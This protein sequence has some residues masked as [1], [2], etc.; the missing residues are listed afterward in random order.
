MP[1]H[2]L[3]ITILWRA[4]QNLV[5]RFIVP[6][7]EKNVR[8]GWF[9]RDC[10]ISLDIT[11]V[12]CHGVALLVNQL[13]LMLMLLL[14]LVHLE[15]AGGGRLL[16]RERLGDMIFNL[17]VTLRLDITFVLLKLS[18]VRLVD[19]VRSLL[20]NRCRVHL[21]NLLLALLPS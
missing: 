13:H 15:M 5:M 10:A 20:G 4:E 18:V 2:V 1:L 3:I 19:R 6:A 9:N 14:L 21:S 11:T 12:V 7:L 8:G 17:I 16:V